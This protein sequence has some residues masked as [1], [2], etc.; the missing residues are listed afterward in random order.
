[1]KSYPNS[2]M[3]FSL[4]DFMLHF[5]KHFGETNSFG[6]ILKEVRAV[7]WRDK[8]MESRARSSPA[9][10]VHKARVQEEGRT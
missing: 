5:L 3:D 7:A 4:W 10:T 8:K 9:R 2:S 1:M 6:K